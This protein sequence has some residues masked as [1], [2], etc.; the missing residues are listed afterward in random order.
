ML[1]VY[2]LLTTSYRESVQNYSIY[3]TE[4]LFVIS[5]YFLLINQYFLY[6]SHI[7]YCQLSLSYYLYSD[8]A[9]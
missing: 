8:H 1:S 7:L 5:F 3:V 6:L 2:Y 9:V 4:Y